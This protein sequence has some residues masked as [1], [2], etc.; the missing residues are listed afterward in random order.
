VA[1]PEAAMIEGLGA[2]VEAG[3]PPV[4][5][6]DPQGEQEESSQGFPFTS[7]S[8]PATQLASLQFP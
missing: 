4:T 3:I 8:L 2:T 6:T 5:A 1:E 7:V